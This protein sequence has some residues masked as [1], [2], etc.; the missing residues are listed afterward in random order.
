MKGP[1][2]FSLIELLVVISIIGF[3]LAISINTFSSFQNGL[4]LK[5]AAEGIASDLKLASDAAKSKKE[6]VAVVFYKDSYEFSLSKKGISP[7]KILNPQTVKF[8][9]SGNPQPGYF[10]TIILTDSKHIKKI[11]I[12]PI[13]RIR[14]A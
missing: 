14:I 13:G 11:I 2:G 5:A 7:L 4:R 6:T 9:E 10:G 8:S 3:I 12:S 1:S